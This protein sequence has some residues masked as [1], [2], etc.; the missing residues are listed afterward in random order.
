VPADPP[1]PDPLAPPAP[2][3]LLLVV[4]PV[5]LVV[6]AV[7]SPPAPVVAPEL[8]DVDD[9]VAALEIGFAASGPLSPPSASTS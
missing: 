2:V 1:P 4:P 5:A 7:A 9:D 6:L 8:E 3:E